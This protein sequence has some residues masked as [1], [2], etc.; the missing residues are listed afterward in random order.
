MKLSIIIVNF[1]TPELTIQAVNSCYKFINNQEFEIIVVD[2]GSTTGKITEEFK[3]FHNLK[4]IESRDNIGFGRANNLGFEN[5]IGKYVLLLNSD[6]YLIDEQS[7]RLM[8]D[9]L[10]KNDKVGIVGPNFLKADGTKNYAYGNL[11]SFR[12]YLSDMGV[13]PISKNNYSNY[14][15]YKVCDV[16]SPT[17]VDY[18]GAAGIILKRDE[19]IKNGLFDPKF[20]LY[21]EDMELGW[22]YNKNGCKSVLLPAAQIVHLGGESSGNLSLFVKGKIEESKIY[23]LKKTFGLPLFYVSQIIKMGYLPIKKIIKKIVR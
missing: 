19:I 12:K 2:N 10:S 8:I 11:L 6:A 23:F 21:F 18:L 3:N 22:R 7:V 15:T 9:Y 13:F 1:N 17:E 20:F 16:D 5:S 14:S 4:L